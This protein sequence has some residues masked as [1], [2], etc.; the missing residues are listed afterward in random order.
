[1]SCAWLVGLPRFFIDACLLRFEVYRE[2]CFYFEVVVLVRYGRVWQRT[3]CAHPVC[4]RCALSGLGR[5]IVLISLA[6]GLGNNHTASLSWI[7]A[8]NVIILSIHQ[9]AQ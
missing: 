8:V 6:H 5:R 7:T 2:N 4:L 3:R 9:F 1:V